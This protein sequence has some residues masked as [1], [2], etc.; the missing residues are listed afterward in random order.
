MEATSLPQEKEADMARIEPID[1]ATS[2]GRA[3][4][5]LEVA[6]SR[7]GAV[8]NMTKTMAVSPATLDGYLGLSGAL[9]SGR[10]GAS[11]GEQIALETAE[12]NGCDYCLAA[13]TYLGKNVARLTDAQILA[14]RRGE[15]SDA[16][17]DAALRFARAVVETRGGVDEEDIQAVR[18]AGHDDEEIAEIVAHVALNVLTN[19]F[20]KMAQVEVDFPHAEPR[21][22][23]A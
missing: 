15:S 12:I 2:E 8:P 20:N 13:H 9:A 18:E 17:A 23:A 10:L 7:L 1:P 5:L 19:Y 4:E 3:K 21:R 14:S 11:L 22:V 16:R 6:K